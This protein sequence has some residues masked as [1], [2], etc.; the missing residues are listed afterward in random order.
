MGCTDDAQA[1]TYWDQI[2]HEKRPSG[3]KQVSY[4]GQLNNGLIIFQEWLKR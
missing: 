3:A 4:W 2:K 1:N